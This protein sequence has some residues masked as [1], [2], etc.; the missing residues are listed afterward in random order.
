MVSGE[1]AS[2]ETL[3]MDHQMSNARPDDRSDGSDE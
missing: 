2:S 1:Y 3:I